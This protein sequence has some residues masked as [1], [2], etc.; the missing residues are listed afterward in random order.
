M[1]DVAIPLNA[2]YTTRYL[3]FYVCVYLYTRTHCYI[4]ADWNNLSVDQWN[5][6]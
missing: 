2:K 1:F 5:I 3:N 6:S 4:S